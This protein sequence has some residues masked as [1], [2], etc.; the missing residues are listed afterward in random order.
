MFDGYSAGPAAV[1]ISFGISILSLIHIFKAFAMES[2][3]PPATSEPSPTA[4][5]S[6]KNFQTGAMPEERFKFDSGQCAT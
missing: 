3:D 1:W 6:S 5:P 4:I 2:E